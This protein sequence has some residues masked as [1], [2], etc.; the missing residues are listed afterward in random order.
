MTAKID[1]HNSS[2][3]VFH[4][5]MH[6]M[7]KGIIQNFLFLLEYCNISYMYSSICSSLTSPGAHAGDSTSSLA[8]C[9]TQRSPRSSNM[10][11]QSMKIFQVRP[12]HHATVGH[13]ISY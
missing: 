5:K 2:K 10:S 11:S 3:F 9:Q 7:L 1:K 13:N 12:H 8:A 6:F 4:T